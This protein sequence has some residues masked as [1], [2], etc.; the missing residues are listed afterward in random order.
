MVCNLCRGGVDFEVHAL[1]STITILLLLLLLLLLLHLRIVLF[2]E[3]KLSLKKKMGTTKAF[4]A[5]AS[6][7][8]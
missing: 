8:G 4:I 3:K 1:S 6:I 2:I 5:K 7:K